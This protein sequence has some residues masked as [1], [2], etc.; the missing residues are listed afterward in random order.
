MVHYNAS[1]VNYR[2]RRDARKKVRLARAL[3]SPPLG[4]TRR[5]RGPYAPSLA[6]GSHEEAIVTMGG[7]K[8]RNRLTKKSG[9]VLPVKHVKTA[10][11]RAAA[12]EGVQL[13]FSKAAVFA[14]TVLEYMVA[15]VLEIAG[16][17]AKAR[18]ARAGR[19]LKVD[20]N[21]VLAAR[22]GD[23]ELQA[24]TRGAVVVGASAPAASSPRP[25]RRR[26]SRRRRT[27]RRPPSERVGRGTARQ[28]K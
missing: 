8:Q 7:N 4:L 10:L 25:R 16:G 9:L 6:N 17:A 5:T 21:D 19:K 13:V 20:S 11:R 2:R 24:W 22:K 26:R 18:H 3:V 28:W 23:D 1:L 15:E 14:T 12:R 27:A